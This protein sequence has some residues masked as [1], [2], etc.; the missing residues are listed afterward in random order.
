MPF[1][2]AHMNALNKPM[3]TRLLLR[4]RRSRCAHS[5][6]AA[7]AERTRKLTFFAVAVTRREGFMAPWTRRSASHEVRAH[8][9][10]Y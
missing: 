6:S 8:R 4:V 10:Y 7:S 1:A 2:R 3:L 9:H 5:F